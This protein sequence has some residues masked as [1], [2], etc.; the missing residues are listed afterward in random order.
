LFF[1][2]PYQLHRT[3]GILKKE[4]NRLAGTKIN[5][6]EKDRNL[7]LAEVD[8]VDVGLGFEIRIRAGRQVGDIPVIAGD[9]QPLCGAEN[10]ILSDH[11][12]QGFLLADRNWRFVLA[13]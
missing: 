1:L 5:V 2:R 10:G 9:P 8:G 4:K 3:F 13:N 7:H 6:F 12:N 11:E